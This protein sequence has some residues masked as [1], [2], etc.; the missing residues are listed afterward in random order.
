MNI[1]N[2]ER[3]PSPGVPACSFVPFVVDGALPLEVPNTIQPLICWPAKISFAF[4]ESHINES[5]GICTLLCLAFSSLSNKN[6]FEIYPCGSLSIYKSLRCLVISL[7][8]LNKAS[9]ILSCR[10]YIV[11]RNMY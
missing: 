4:L 3:F 10:Y 2:P 1:Q 8:H 11:F 9:V 6:S 7:A 5:N